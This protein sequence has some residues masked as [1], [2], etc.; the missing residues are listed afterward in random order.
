MSMP[1][2]DAVSSGGGRSIMLKRVAIVALLAPLTLGNLSRPV[3]AAGWRPL[4]ALLLASHLPISPEAGLQRG[5]GVPRAP[6]EPRTY[7]GFLP[8]AGFC[9]STYYHSVTG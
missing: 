3:E 8:C 4:A 9:S 7:G 6:D 1:A 2:R 5:G